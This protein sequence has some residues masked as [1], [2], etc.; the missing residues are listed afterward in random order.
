M[1]ASDPSG[2]TQAAATT[3]DLLDIGMG[4]QKPANLIEEV[5]ELSDLLGTTSTT[6]SATT[7]V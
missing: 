7:G 2:N 6:T 1:T 4:A 5:K 3:G